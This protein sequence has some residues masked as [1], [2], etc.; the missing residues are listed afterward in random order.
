MNPHRSTD[1]PSPLGWLNIIQRGGTA[2][3]QELYARC[4]DREFAAQVASMLRFRDPDLMASA[5]LWK[6]LLEDLH[7]GLMADL[8]EDEAAWAA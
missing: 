6:F 1:G 2:D 3:W 7:P 8:R 4:A 5:R